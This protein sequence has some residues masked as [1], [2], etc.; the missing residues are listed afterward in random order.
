M[1]NKIAEIYEQLISHKDALCDAIRVLNECL[2]CF[3]QIVSCNGDCPCSF[4]EAWCQTERVTSPSVLYKDLFDVGILTHFLD[5][6][7]LP[8]VNESQKNGLLHAFRRL[9]Q[10]M[11][12][13][14]K[15]D[16]IIQKQAKLSVRE[17]EWT[18]VFGTH[19]VKKLSISRDM[20]ISDVGYE[21]Y[22]V[23]PC[24][25]G[26]EL[27]Y[28]DTSM[29]S[30]QA[31]HGSVDILTGCVA[32]EVSSILIPED[33]E[34]STSALEMKIES[35]ERH[36]HQLVA[37]TI[38]SSCIQ[39]RGLTPVI[40]VSK[41]DIKV[42][43]YDY[44]SDLLFES[45]EFFFEEQIEIHTIVALWLAINYQLF[46]LDV[47][48]AIKEA[49]YCANFKSVLHQKNKLEIYENEMHLFGCKEDQTVL[50]PLYKVYAKTK[51]T[52]I[53]VV[54]CSSK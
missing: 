7:I 39:N 14:K 47:N 46:G 48:P 4:S 52:D 2:V 23:C 37:K 35:L 3:V 28:G 20:K 15:I 45:E 40:A 33:E 19:L 24:G 25:C 12:N 50:P 22:R 41:T 27:V 36:R 31:W 38:V 21:K 51:G 18:G 42:F 49:G 16:D 54:H 6:G 8:D 10:F 43:L 29:G 53:H 34:P 30:K 26:E 13:Y 9:A 32:I 5:T 17:I 1:S 44:D 11:D